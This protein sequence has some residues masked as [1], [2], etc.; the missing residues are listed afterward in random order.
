MK[1]EKNIKKIKCPIFH[2]KNED[3]EGITKVINAVEDVE[4]KARLSGRLIKEAGELLSCKYF[5]EKRRC[6]RS[7]NKNGATF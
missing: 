6:G 4:K 2:S 7:K 3:I 5:Y 1:N